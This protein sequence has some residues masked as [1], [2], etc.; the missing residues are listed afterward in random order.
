VKEMTDEQAKKLTDRGVT[1]DRDPR[2]LLDTVASK[3]LG[4]K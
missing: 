2:R 4:G 1:L 3:F